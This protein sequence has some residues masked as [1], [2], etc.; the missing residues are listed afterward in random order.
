MTPRYACGTSRRCGSA[1][2]STATPR[3]GIRMYVP[4]VNGEAPRELCRRHSR[5][6]HRRPAP[7]AD[8]STGSI[9]GERRRGIRA[10]S[11]DATERT[12]HVPAAD[13]EQ[14]RKRLDESVPRRPPLP[15]HRLQDR[16]CGIRPSAAAR[17]AASRRESIPSASP[18][19]RA[20]HLA[21][22]DRALDAA[23]GRHDHLGARMP[24]HRAARAHDGAESRRFAPALELLEA[25]VQAHSSTLA[26]ASGEGEAGVQGQ[27]PWAICIIGR[28]G[29]GPARGRAQDLDRLH[30]VRRGSIDEFA[31]DHGQ[32]SWISRSG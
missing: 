3:V 18:M 14:R 30:A 22:A 21:A 6:T 31:P 24:W 13:D 15:R 19:T 10:T 17:G 26:D 23:V 2:T 16:R 20:L 12:A 32:K 7:T 29:T 11:R 27:G 9:V 25:C 5:D 1:S 8:C 4:V 28:I